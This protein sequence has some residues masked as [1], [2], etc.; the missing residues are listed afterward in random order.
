MY[1]AQLDCSS[2]FEVE[3]TLQLFINWVTSCVSEAP[4]LYFPQAAKR[5]VL[6]RATS[7]NA[8]FFFMFISFMFNLNYIKNI[9]ELS[10]NCQQVSLTFLN[11]N[12]SFYI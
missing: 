6:A 7:D 12:V 3:T 1:C 5:A 2:L 9:P 4:T 10:E 8:N 11:D